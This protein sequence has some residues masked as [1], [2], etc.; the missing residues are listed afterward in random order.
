MSEFVRICQ[1]LL[2]VLKYEEISLRV[3]TS[4]FLGKLGYFPERHPLQS[5]SAADQLSLLLSTGDPVVSTY[6]LSVPCG[7]DTISGWSAGPA[8]QPPASVLTSLSCSFLT[9]KV[10]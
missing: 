4:V 7:P 6:S 1:D 5:L 8:V 9:S 2:A 3:E 10:G